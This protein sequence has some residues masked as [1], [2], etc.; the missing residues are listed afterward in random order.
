[1]IIG[2]ATLRMSSR[3]VSVHRD[4]CRDVF[5]SRTQLQ[6]TSTTFNLLTHPPMWHA[7]VNFR[8]T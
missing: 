5:P 4:D 3:Y 7:E 1:M 6:L 8:V 2:V